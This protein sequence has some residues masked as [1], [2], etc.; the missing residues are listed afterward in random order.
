M[1]LNDRRNDIYGLVNNV[2]LCQK[3]CSFKSYNSTSKKSKCNCEIQ[4]KKTIIE[5]LTD[6]VDNFEKSKEIIDI[7]QNPLSLSN[8]K[9]LKCY[10][11]FGDFKNILYNYGCLILSAFL[12]TFVVLMVKYFISGYISINNYIKNILDKKKI[13]FN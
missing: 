13:S 5:E 8:I 6:I 10:Q 1:N 7:F 11:I 2:S 4:E 9:V 3:G 12:I